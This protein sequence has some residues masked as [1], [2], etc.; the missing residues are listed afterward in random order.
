MDIVYILVNPAM[1]GYIKVGYTSNL[2]Q[3]LK[4]LDNTSVPVPFEC[5][6][7]IE[8]EDAKRV[9]K[10]VHD[11]FADMRVNPRREFFE[12]NQDRVISALKLTGGNEVNL[13]KD[14]DK[15]LDL[16]DVKAREKL[17]K[18]RERFNFNMIGISQG[19]ELHFKKDENIKCRVISNNK[20]EFEGKELT[21]S[22]SASYLLTTQFGFT[23][24]HVSG[25]YYW[26]FDGES[27]YDRR[28]RLEEE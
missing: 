11:V 8:V 10:R 27:L 22:S 17:Q 18:T 12:I 3:R 20:I 21:L 1:E 25:S 19:N 4:D 9:E 16:S 23:N 15:L 13:Q 14:V 24:T 7:A 6:F 26:C 2:S 28:K 5:V